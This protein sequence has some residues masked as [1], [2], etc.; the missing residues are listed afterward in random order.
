MLQMNKLHDYGGVAANQ[1]EVL[2]MLGVLR[3]NPTSEIHAAIRDDLK[4]TGKTEDEAK[5]ELKRLTVSR[6]HQR[7]AR[8]VSSLLAQ[9]PDQYP[10]L[11]DP[12]DAN[13]DLAARARSYLHANCSQCHVE[14]GGGNAQIDLEFTTPLEKTKILDTPPLHHKFGVEDARLIAAGDPDRSIL[15]HRIA[16]RGEGQMPQL[17]TTVVDEQAVELLRQWV[18]ELGESPQPRSDATR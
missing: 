15:L 7:A 6:D 17:A 13:Q 5:R 9:S 14:A 12:Y 2:E 18:L 4:T 8:E 16:R 10:H 3:V 11:V 1:L